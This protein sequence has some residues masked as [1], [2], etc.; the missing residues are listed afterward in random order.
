MFRCIC[1][2]QLCVPSGIASDFRVRHV[3]YANRFVQSALDGIVYTMPK[4]LERVEGYKSIPLTSIE[5]EAFAKD[6]I[7]LRFD[8]DRYSVDPTA[9]LD[10]RRMGDTG[11]DLWTVFSRI[12]E[13][14][15]RGGIASRTRNG[16]Q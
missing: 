16:R 13:N 9:M 15:I 14:V 3:G 7:E 11:D 5:Q 1:S 2:N 8:G 10:R 6:A 4:T 12:Q